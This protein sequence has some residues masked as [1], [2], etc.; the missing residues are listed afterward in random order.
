[1]CKVKNH[2]NQSCLKSIYCSFIHCHL[3]YG[4][5]VCAGTNKMKLQKQSS[6]FVC[7]EGRFSNGKKV[8]TK[9]NTKLNTILRTL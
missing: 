3:D 5:S 2:L 8:M 1:M 4:N 7:S 9:A 6:R